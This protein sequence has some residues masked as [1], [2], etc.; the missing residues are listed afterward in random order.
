MPTLGKRVKLP[1]YTF[2]CTD[3]REHLWSDIWLGI[4]EVQNIAWVLDAVFGCLFWWGE[5]VVP[6]AM[7]ILETAC[8]IVQLI[9]LT[10]HNGLLL[11]HTVE[12]GNYTFT[13]SGSS[14]ILK[15]CCST[16]GFTASGQQELLWEQDGINSPHIQFLSKE[17][18][19]VEMSDGTIHCVAVSHLHHGSP[20]LALHEL[21]LWKVSEDSIGHFSTTQR[22]PGS[23]RQ[24]LKWDNGLEQR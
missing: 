18:V 21:H 6:G 24:R 3:L 1:S 15:N 17:E 8:A 5:P 23:K 13:C 16:A 22:C 4:E 20:W 12:R 2:L 9:A 7:E 10:G 19:V 11:G 14:H